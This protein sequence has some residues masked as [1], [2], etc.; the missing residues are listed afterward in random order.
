MNIDVD[1]YWKRV[2]MRYRNERDMVLEENRI[3]QKVLLEKTGRAHDGADYLREIKETE[4]RPT[5]KQRINQLFERTFR[6][7]T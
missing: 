4:T 6:G 7:T 2:A 3:L 1:S 5:V